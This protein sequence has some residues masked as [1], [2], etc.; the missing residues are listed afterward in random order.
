MLMY[1][2]N[3]MIVIALIS[4]QKHELDKHQNRSASPVIKSN[5]LTIACD[6]CIC[7]VILK[8][9]VNLSVQD[10]LI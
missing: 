1:A 9:S 8:G 6:I 5:F 2:K 4:H 7:N 10:Q 3:D